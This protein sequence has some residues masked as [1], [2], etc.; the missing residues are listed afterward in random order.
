[1][2]QHTQTH[3]AALQLRLHDCVNGFIV[4]QGTGSWVYTIQCSFIGLVDQVHGLTT[5]QVQQ[6][7]QQVAVCFQGN[8][9][10]S[11]NVENLPV[12]MQ[13]IVS[14]LKQYVMSPQYFDLITVACYW[15][16]DFILSHLS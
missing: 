14:L 3:P 15:G 4:M 11:K 2:P 12:L 1:M 16:N 13:I 6:L 5:K 9:G 10:D 7:F 8:R